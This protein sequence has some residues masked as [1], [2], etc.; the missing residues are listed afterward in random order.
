MILAVGSLVHV[1]SVFGNLDELCI[2]MSP[3]RPE[4]LGEPGGNFYYEVY[5]FQSRERF[6]AFDYEMILIGKDDFVPYFTKG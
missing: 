2:I 1:K 5:C 3:P 4:F 6:L